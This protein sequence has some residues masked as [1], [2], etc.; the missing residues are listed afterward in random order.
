MIELLQ[1]SKVLAKT[2]NI[3]AH[4]PL[5]IEIFEYKNSDLRPQLAA[6]SG[7][8]KKVTFQDIVDFAQKADLL[9]NE[10]NELFLEVISFNE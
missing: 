6:Y 1:E 9:A 3:I 4:N 7:N 5:Q 10:L 2:R 8:A